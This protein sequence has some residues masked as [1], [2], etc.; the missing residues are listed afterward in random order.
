MFPNINPR[1]IHQAMKKLG[2]SQEEV[3]AEQVIIKTKGKDIIILEPSVQKI[4]MS[5]QL[6]FQISGRVTEKPSEEFSVTDED[7][8]TVSEQANISREDAEKLIKKHKGDL[9]AAILEASEKK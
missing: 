4:N 9:A 1:Q 5:G 7:I 6:S 3:D 8:K 2:I